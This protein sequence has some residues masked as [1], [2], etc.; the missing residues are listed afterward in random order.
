M[1]AVTDFQISSNS[2][3]GALPGSGLQVM[4]AVTTF[5][6][7][8]NVFNGTLPKSGM[9]MMSAVTMFQ[10]SSNNFEGALPG[11]GLEVMRAVT[12]FLT[13]RN[14]FKGTLPERG[15]RMMSTVMDFQISSNSFK[16]ALP[17]SGFQVMRAMRSFE[18]AWNGFKGTI[19]ESGIRTMSAV[20]R[21][22]IGMNSFQGA[23]PGS[24]L[25][26]L[27]AMSE[28]MIARNGFKGTVPDSG[29]RSMSVVTMLGL[30]TNSFE[31][32]LPESGL[33]TMRTMIFLYVDANRFAGTL[34][35]RAFAG[36]GAAS[37][38]NNDFEGKNP[39]WTLFCTSKV[40][41]TV[42]ARHFTV[43]VSSLVSLYP[44]QGLEML[45][46]Q[47]ISELVNRDRCYTL[48]I[49]STGGLPQ[50]QLAGRA[51][52]TSLAW[53]QQAHPQSRG[54]QSLGLS[55]ISAMP[56]STGGVADPKIAPMSGLVS[57][58]QSWNGIRWFCLIWVEWLWLQ[59]EGL[60]LEGTIPETAS[61]LTMADITISFGH[62]L[63]GV[64]PSI[65][66][67][68]GLL[69]LWENGL[70]RHLP[71]LHINQTSTLLLYNNDFSCKLPRHYGAKPT[72]T[73][74]LSL[75]GNHFTKPRCV[76]TW[77]MPAEQPA[78]MFCTSNQQSTR[79]IMLL[80]C[81]GC[82]FVLAT[83]LLKRKALPMCGDQR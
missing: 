51:N 50:P 45:C 9:R 13:N 12:A 53:R 36:L 17:G 6:T 52:S 74:S 60:L 79:F 71:A 33:Q 10:I 42:L 22:L 35:T 75:I 82:C 63:K 67:T 66:G 40:S 55:H 21:F 31:G 59:A 70:E 15:I 61:R 58:R 28:F 46:S 29:V 18:L 7:D 68:V 73:E 16:G 80:F 20:W 32:A 24:G 30:S 47:R 77:I 37:V 44:G 48:I 11:S 3:K 81:G 8:R 1:S 26:G 39:T 38:S 43:I 4:R 25:Q 2:F 64:L 56:L 69:S 41:S 34:P 23:L 19:P 78:D 27:R 83:F 49:G 5:L 76:P 54:S 72:S 62:G 14:V 57:E 65:P